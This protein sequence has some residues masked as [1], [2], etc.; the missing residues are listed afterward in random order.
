MPWYWWFTFFL[1][2]DKLESNFDL[3]TKRKATVLHCEFEQKEKISALKASFRWCLSGLCHIPSLSCALWNIWCFTLQEQ[4]SSLQSHIT[5]EFAKLHLI[6][7][8]QEQHL[9]RDLGEQAD[10]ISHRMENNLQE[11]QI[12][13]HSIEQKLSDLQKVV[14]EKDA[15]TFLQVNYNLSAV[16]AINSMRK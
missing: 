3:V 10:E 7:A 2:Q 15:L 13:L 1:I 6:L 16:K 9:I 12:N 5:A 8:E 11:I 4:A 14:M